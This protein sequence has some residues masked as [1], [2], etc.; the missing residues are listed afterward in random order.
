MENIHSFKTSCDYHEDIS[1][2]QN[3]SEDFIREFQDKVDW[4]E[5]SCKII[6]QK[7]SFGSFKIKWIGNLFQNIKIYQISFKSL[8]IK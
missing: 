7:I 1:H 2:Q 8:K 6:Y 3:L 4:V 5:I